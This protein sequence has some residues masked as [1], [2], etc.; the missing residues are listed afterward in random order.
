MD[1]LDEYA[2]QFTETRAEARRLTSGLSPEQFNWRPATG[3]WSVAECLGHLTVTGRQVCAKMREAIAVGRSRGLTGTGPFDYGWLSR[4]FES[5][6][7]PPPRRRIPTARAFAPAARSTCEVDAVLDDFEAVGDEYRACLAA[8]RGLDLRRV[9]V[10]SPVS[11]LL[12]FPLGGYIRGQ[13]AHERRHL[14][15]ARQVISD[16]RFP[17]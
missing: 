16:A 14:W 15:Q 4:W 7:E 6:M 5:S 13:T 8:A 10:Q 9:R 2:R 3:R 17:R 1:E 12:R 11:R